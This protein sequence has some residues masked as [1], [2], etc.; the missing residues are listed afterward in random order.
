[1]TGIVRQGKA[2]ARQ[3]AGSSGDGRTRKQSA[4][5]DHPFLQ[6]CWNGT[7]VRVQIGVWAIEVQSKQRILRLKPQSGIKFL[8][9]S[10]VRPQRYSKAM[11]TNSNHAR[12]AMAMCMCMS[13][14]P[15][16]A[17]ETRMR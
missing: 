13:G 5:R 17:A 14:G 12:E 9:D 16:R 11:R 6:W 1:M 7:I 15:V 10:E 3:C 2:S 8:F 4:A